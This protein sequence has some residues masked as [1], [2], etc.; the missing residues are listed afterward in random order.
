MSRQQPCGQRLWSRKP[1]CK[2]SPGKLDDHSLVVLGKGEREGLCCI[3]EAHVAGSQDGLP[4][5]LRN[6]QV[7]FHHQAK[8][9]VV[10]GIGTYGVGLARVGHGTRVDA[11]E[12]ARPQILNVELG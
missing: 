4:S 12:L 9:Q 2:Q 3:V 6:V 10:T 8:L 5:F 7:A 11:T 1:G